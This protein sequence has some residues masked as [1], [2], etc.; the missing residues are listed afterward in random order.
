MYTIIFY[1]KL[2]VYY[3]Y[4]IDYILVIFK[5]YYNLLD[6]LIKFT[7]YTFIYY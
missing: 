6:L 3:K 2:N 4:L 7:Y 5:M 1:I